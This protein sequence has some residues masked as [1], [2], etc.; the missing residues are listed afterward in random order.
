[1]AKERLKHKPASFKRK[2]K[3]NKV[4]P[5]PVTASGQAGEDL[6]VVLGTHDTAAHSTERDNAW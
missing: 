1:M 6:A 4:N 3:S 5:R 2:L